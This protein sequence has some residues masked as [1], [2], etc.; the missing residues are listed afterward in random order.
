MIDENLVLAFPPEIS[1]GK[2]VLPKA[3]P[4]DEPQKNNNYTLL[5]TPILH[6]IR[7]VKANPVLS[8]E[9]SFRA[10]QIIVSCASMHER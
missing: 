5:P 3:P 9:P 2:A 6:K 7:V 1:G 4:P 8:L 10:K